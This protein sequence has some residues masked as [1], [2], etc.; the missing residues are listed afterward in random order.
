M[1]PVNRKFI[2]LDL[3]EMESFNAEYILESFNIIGNTSGN[4]PI[5]QPTLS[6]VFASPFIKQHT[7]DVYLTETTV[8]KKVERLR[9]LDVLEEGGVAALYRN[10][11]RTKIELVSSSAGQIGLRDLRADY[12][13]T[14]PQPQIPK[15]RVPER[16]QKSQTKQEIARA[17]M[18]LERYN[19]NLATLQNKF[20]IAPRAGVPAPDGQEVA[21]VAN[22]F[23]VPIV[24][25]IRKKTAGDETTAMPGVGR[26]DLLKK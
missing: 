13:A 10:K 7:E 5:H 23:D 6:E 14:H 20:E 22:L 18:E 4:K 2:I 16:L 11:K 3:N 1:L 17:A 24:G 19:R 12:I 9:L 15:S 26:P 21:W 25:K 8:E